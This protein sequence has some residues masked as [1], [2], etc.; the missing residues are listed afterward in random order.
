MSL[1]ATSGSALDRRLSNLAACRR[2]LQAAIAFFEPKL[3]QVI[4]EQDERARLA[5]A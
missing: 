5:H 3:A 2:Q 4:A 1:D